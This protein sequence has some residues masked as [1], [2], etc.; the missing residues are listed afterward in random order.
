MEL[1][2]LFPPLP[3]STLVI[4]DNQNIRRRVTWAFIRRQVTS[5]NIQLNFFSCRLRALPL[6]PSLTPP[7][8][9]RDHPSLFDL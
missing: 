5:S 4:A 7:D 6:Q 9:G 2:R 1:V 3:V 8:A